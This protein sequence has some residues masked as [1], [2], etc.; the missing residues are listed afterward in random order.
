[1]RRISYCSDYNCPFLA[2][3]FWILN[4][5]LYAAPAPH[6][7]SGQSILDK[8]CLWLPPA[9]PS[10]WNPA[11]NLAADWLPENTARRP[12]NENRFAL[13]RRNPPREMPTAPLADPRNRP[14][15]KVW[16]E[17]HIALASSNRV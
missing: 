9:T 15:M 13:H 10:S 17:F 16:P 2:S 7:K 4:S 3:D 8:P 14:P 11:T 1:M 5:C 12:A 6:S